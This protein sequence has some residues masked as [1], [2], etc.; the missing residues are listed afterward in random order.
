MTGGAQ[1]PPP[2]DGDATTVVDEMARP[3]TGRASKGSGLIPGTSR[4]VTLVTAAVGLVLLLSVGTAV[5]LTLARSG[6]ALPGTVVRG[7]DVGGLSEADVRAALAPR[8]ANLAARAVTF[9]GPAGAEY[10]VTAAKIGYTVDLEATARAA[11][12]AGRSGNLVSRV[13]ATVASTWTTRTVPLQD[14]Y[15]TAELRREVASLAAKADREV[16]EGGFTVEGTTVTTRLPADG[17]RTDQAAT[18]AAVRDSL[19]EPKPVVRTL[20]GT[21]TPSGVDP[22]SVRAVA[23]QARRALSQS[24]E[25]ADGTTRVTVP[26]AS[27]GAL[28]SSTLTAEGAAGTLRTASLSLDTE[29][30][31]TL[32]ST[33]TEPVLV[34]ARSARFR[35]TAPP[36][37]VDAQGDLTFTPLPAAVTVVGT[38]RDGRGVD[39]P[40][41]T[42]GLADAVLAGG[43]SAPLVL[44]VDKPAVTEAQGAEITHLIGTFTTRYVAGQPRVTNIHRIAEIVSGTVIP[45]GGTFSLNGVA[46]KRTPEKGFVKD[47]AIL[48]GELVDQYGGGV[49]QFSTTTFNAAFFSGLPI[50]AYKA[51]SFYIS[52]YPPGRE[53]TLNFPTVDLA[54]TNDTAH[55]ILV[56]ASYTATSV[57]VV[58]LRRQRRPHGQ[59]ALGPARG[60]AQGRGRRVHHRGHPDGQRRRQG[61]HPDVPDPVRGP[62]GRSLTAGGGGNAQLMVWLVS[63]TEASSSRSLSA[64]CLPWWAQNSS[65]PPPGRVART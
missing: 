46:G 62:A 2:N 16:A 40:K 50:N 65:S 60:Q 36:P 29:G 9:T 38:A 54:W 32:V 5:A 10:S 30:L 39:V 64:Y 55:P 7:V 44:T 17:F 58:A 20:P 61:Q 31:S 1:L 49:S 63:V 41:T 51:H 3:A 26:A 13:A 19:A 43:H 18:V 12:Q 11:L 52:R 59:L 24:F 35:A 42:A 53:S 45:A 28:L 15:D 37:V 22:A 6:E 48:G 56:Q 4:A 33:R 27:V 47:S 23:D 34:A 57:T 8:A 14:S 25:L 21:V